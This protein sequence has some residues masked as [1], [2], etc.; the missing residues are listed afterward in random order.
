[1]NTIQKFMILEIL[2]IVFMVLMLVMV[3]M[4][5]LFIAVITSRFARKINK[6]EYENYL[7]S[8]L[9]GFTG[10]LFVFIMTLLFDA[11][12][13][14]IGFIG[15]LFS[16]AGASLASASVISLGAFFYLNTNIKKRKK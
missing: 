4:C 3:F 5:V 10:G 13:E 16:I 9:S 2:L 6:E 8:I 12:R 15:L 7:K 14:G 11:I 1:M